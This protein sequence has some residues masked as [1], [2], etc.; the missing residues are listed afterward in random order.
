M[1]LRLKPS[2][3]AIPAY[4]IG[5]PAGAAALIIDGDHVT[6]SGM[7]ADNSFHMSASGPDGAWFRIEVSSN[8]TDWAPITYGQVI[9]GSVDFID[10]DASNSGSRF[11]RA[12][13]ELTVPVE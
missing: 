3:E 5:S 9:N 8:M 4:L 11:Y 10:P 2:P 12:V 13:P 1:V 7:L 6:S